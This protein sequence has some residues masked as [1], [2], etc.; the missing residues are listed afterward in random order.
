MGKKK[1]KNGE[2][3]RRRGEPIE[4]IDRC[5][6]PDARRSL[7][8]KGSWEKKKKKR[9]G[10]C[11]PDENRVKP[12]KKKGDTA[13]GIDTVWGRP[14]S[15]KKGGGDKGHDGKTRESTSRSTFHQVRKTGV[16]KGR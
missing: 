12:R 11:R 10:I 13:E 4:K 9:D 1:R 2:Y 6:P 7:K 8:K 16:K 15:K 3:W 14:R 5:L